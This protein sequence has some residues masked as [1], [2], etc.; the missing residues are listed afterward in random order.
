MTEWLAE[1]A[2]TLVGWA[3]AVGAAIFVVG[4]KF[5]RLEDEGRMTT[6]R[7][8]RLA[9]AVERLNA[10][11]H[12]DNS[13]STLAKSLQRLA[14]VIE[15]LSDRMRKSE[16]VLA[17]HEV[18]LGK[19]DALMVQQADIVRTLSEHGLILARIDER[20]SVFAHRPGAK[21]GQ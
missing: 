6:E 14:E 19:I 13:N 10:T 17:D 12:G 20:C 21:A 2:A 7:V 18:R 4:K 8:E 9:T 11:V 15:E 1:N 5:G 16:S 3:G